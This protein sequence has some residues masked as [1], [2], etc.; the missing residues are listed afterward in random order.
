VQSYLMAARAAVLPRVT[1][2]LIDLGLR[3]KSSS[4]ALRDKPEVRMSCCGCQELLWPAVRAW[5]AP[6][7]GYEDPSL[8]LVETYV[9]VDWLRACMVFAGGIA[10]YTASQELVSPRAGSL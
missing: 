1:K 10:I 8:E 9:Q 2:G 3:Q 6:P 4:T 7:P 5:I